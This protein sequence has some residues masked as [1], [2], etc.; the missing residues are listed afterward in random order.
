M[1]EL[2]LFPEEAWVEIVRQGGTAVNITT[3]IDS[4]EEGG[5]EREVEFRPFFH[6]AKVTIKKQQSSGEITVNAKITR[7]LWDN[8]LWGATG[9]DF[10][11][12]GEQD[13]YR[14]TFLVTKQNS[15]T[16]ATEALGS[17]F[18]HYRKIYAN[19]FMTSF[20]PKLEVEGML[21]GEATFMVS[22]LDE[23][24]DAN[25]RVQIGS[26]AF[27]AIGSYTSSQKW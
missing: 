20:N 6:N 7:E 1:A 24:G 23:A 3:D 18:D 26:E 25:V 27:A 16:S 11:A 13:P 4:F 12:G 19:A 10:T 2:A 8:I 9:S 15:V 22:P 14:I 17:G 21:E 5:F